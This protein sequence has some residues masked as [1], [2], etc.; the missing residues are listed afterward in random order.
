[1][2][3]RPSQNAFCSV[4]LIALDSLKISTCCL[5]SHNTVLPNAFQTDV[6]VLRRLTSNRFVGR[7]RKC[8][9][10]VLMLHV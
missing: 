8:D 6:A 2:I 4:Y 9:G 5:V 10:F 1:M 7:V 3:L